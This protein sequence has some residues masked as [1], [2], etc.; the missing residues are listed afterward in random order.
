MVNTFVI[1]VLRDDLIGRCLETMYRHT[2]NNFYVYIIDQTRGGINKS[3]HKY[4]HHYIRPYRNLGFAKSF[5]TGL[6][7]CETPYVTT[8]NDDIEFVNYRWWE[9]IEQT[10]DK[11]DSATPDKP[12]AMVTPSSIKLPDWS[13]GR[14]SGDHFYIQQY[15]EFYSDEDYDHLLNDDHYVNEHL[16]IKPNT[17][18]DGVTMY[19]SIFNKERLDKIGWLNERYY[20]GCGEDYDWGCRAN[21]MGYRSCGTTLSWVYHHWSKSLSSVNDYADLIDQ[22]RCWNKTNETWG[23]G[24]D[25]WGVRCPECNEHMRVVGDHATCSKNHTQYEMPPNRQIPL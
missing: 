2:P 11:V 6:K 1:A 5:N 12:C 23:T 21:M 17:V 14:P 24:F 15:K 3:L 19:C 4:I 22:S 13:V 7:L 10:F 9:G 20:P 18:I 16:T 25:L 8:C